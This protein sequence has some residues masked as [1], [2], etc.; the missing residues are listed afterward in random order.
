MASCSDLMIQFITL[1]SNSSLGKLSFV[2]FNSWIKYKSD[3]S[4]F[5]NFIKCSILALTEFT[6]QVV[7]FIY[8]EK[9]VPHPHEEDASGLEILK[10]D[11]INSLT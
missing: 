3:W 5:I 9:E 4:F 2:H 7:I 11:P 8:I 6:F 10:D 1:F